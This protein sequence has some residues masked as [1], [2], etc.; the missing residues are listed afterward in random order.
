MV[1]AGADYVFDENYELPSLKNIENYISDNKNLPG[2][3]S[4]SEMKTNGMELGDM[5]IK[6]LQKI[7]ELTLRLIR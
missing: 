3:N 4:A 6:L 1:T 2:I 7:E 5:N